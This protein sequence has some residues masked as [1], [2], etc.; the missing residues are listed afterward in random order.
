[1]KDLN[2]GALEDLYEALLDVYGN[3]ELQNV[4]G[5]SDELNIQVQRAIVRAQWGVE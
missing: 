1:M 3:I 4:E 5:G 2:P